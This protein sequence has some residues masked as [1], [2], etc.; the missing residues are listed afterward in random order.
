MITVLVVDDHPLILEAWHSALGADPDISVDAVATTVP[1]ALEAIATHPPFDI[2]V[3]DIR[4]GSDSGFG[5][6]PALDL[7]RTGVVMVSAHGS[8]VYV[9]A[10]QRL[11]V[12]GFFLKTSSTAAIIAGVK[13][14][15]GGSTAWDPEAMHQSAHGYWHPLSEREYLVID[16]VV[17]GR[18]NSEIGLDLGIATKTVESHL[19]K[20]Y[21]RFGVTSRIELVRKAIEEGWLD[22]RPR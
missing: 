17:A 20:L 21:T 2:V 18:S 10:A 9:D 16:A 15:A 14:V 3:T 6:L 7:L 19:T 22:V 4:L 13:R 12:R 8:P 1:E 11:G 5:I